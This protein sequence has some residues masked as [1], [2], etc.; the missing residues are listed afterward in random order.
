MLEYKTPMLT[1]HEAAQELG[2]TDS[3]IC[4]LCREGVIDAHKHANVWVIPAPELQR[5][6]RQERDPRGRPRS[7][8]PL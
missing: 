3:Y 6:S 5:Y 7:G 8:D 2:V 4:W 1:S